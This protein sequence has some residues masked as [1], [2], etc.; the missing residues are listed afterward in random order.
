MTLYRACVLQKLLY[1]APESWAPTESQLQQLEVFNT[2]CLRSII[3]APHR[4]P[5]MISNE[6]LYRVTGQ[7]RIREILRKR[8][9]AWLGHVARK[10]EPGAATRHLLFATAPGGRKTRAIGGAAST[11][12]AV[13]ARDLEEVY[14]SREA[15]KD[16]HSECLNRTRWQKR[17][18]PR[19]EEEESDMID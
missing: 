18:A 11:W 15:A 3:G 1:G 13:A 12:G 16:W 5:S 6:E 9:L 10:Q 14:G 8:R 2:T 17:V 7:G 19:G 4:H